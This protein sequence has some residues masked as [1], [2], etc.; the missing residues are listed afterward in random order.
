VL[1]I[2]I[3]AMSLIWFKVV[4]V[5]EKSKKR[6]NGRMYQYVVV[7]K[8]VELERVKLFPELLLK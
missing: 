5:I 6:E 8:A 4:F 7:L 3:S 2:G 1:Y